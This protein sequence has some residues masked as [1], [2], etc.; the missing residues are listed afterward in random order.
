MIDGYCDGENNQGKQLPLVKTNSSINHNKS[1]R[2]IIYFF[3]NHNVK[4]ERSFTMAACHTLSDK[5][6]IIDDSAVKSIV[7]N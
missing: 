3:S 2:V 5:T 4:S 1:A 7:E 6:W